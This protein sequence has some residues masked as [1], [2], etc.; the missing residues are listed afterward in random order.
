MTLAMGTLVLFQRLWR[1]PSQI[2]RPRMALYR[3]IISYGD[4]TGVLETFDDLDRAVAFTE[5]TVASLVADERE[6]QVSEVDRWSR[7]SW[8]LT[9]DMGPTYLRIM[10]WEDQDSD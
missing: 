3:V 4:D 8:R 7:R 1:Q 5:E 9:T 6:L 2:G 10:D